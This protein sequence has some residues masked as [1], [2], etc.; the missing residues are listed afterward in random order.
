MDCELCGREVG[1]GRFEHDACLAE[2]AGRIEEKRC[3]YCGEWG[4]INPAL[5]QG[6]RP[7][8]AIIQELSLSVKTVFHSTAS[9]ILIEAGMLATP[10]T[11]LIYMSP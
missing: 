5:M 9:A 6:L 4:K 1:V 8:S 7:G 11:I 2:Y 3:L 10:Y